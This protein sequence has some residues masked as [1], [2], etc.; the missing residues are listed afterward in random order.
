MDMG[1]TNGQWLAIWSTVGELIIKEGKAAVAKYAEGLNIKHCR[2]P[3]AVFVNEN[4]ITG[5]A[6]VRF[7]CTKCDHVHNLEVKGW[8]FKNPN[9]VSKEFLR[10]CLE[11]MK[12][13]KPEFNEFSEAQQRG[14][15]EITW[16]LFNAYESYEEADAALK[17]YRNH[18]D[19]QSA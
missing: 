7:T 9:P 15:V 12:Q 19:E 1:K 6:N 14:L 2:K 11:Q 13:I 18:R 17:A 5:K 3:V 4:L 10:E 8:R 16:I